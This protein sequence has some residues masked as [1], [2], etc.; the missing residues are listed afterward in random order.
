MTPQAT[1]TIHRKLVDSLYVEAMLLA[2]EARAY[3]DVLGRAERDSLEA[4]SRV[5]FSCESLKVTTRLMHIIAWLLTQRAVEAGELTPVEALSPSRRLGEAPE[6]DAAI[7]E[8]MPAQARAIIATSIELHRRVARLD[9]S[10]DEPAADA[11]PARRMLERLS[12][13]F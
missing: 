10:L 12:A 7:L 13:S 8:T 5:T 3:F 6:T 1:S 4:L 11:S 2:D 9:A